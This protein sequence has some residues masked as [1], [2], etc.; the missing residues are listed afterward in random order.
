MHDR[1]GQQ[2]SSQWLCQA[3]Q[4]A[5][6]MGVL[7]CTPDS[8]SD[9]GKF[10]DVDRAV[11]HGLAMWN[12]GA[13]IIDVGGESTRPGAKP[14]AE[15]E[16]LQRVMPVIKALVAKGCKVS[17]DTRH[18]MVMKQA[19]QAGA[20]MI[21]DVS[22]LLFDDKSLDVAV[23]ATLDAEVDVCLM[24]MQGTPE[25]MQQAPKYHDVLSEVEAFFEKCLERCLCAGI[26]ES[27]LLLDPG[28]GFGKSVEDN[29]VLIANIGV[30][31]ERFGLPILL[32]VSR[33]S[34]IGSLTGGLVD[35]RELETAVAG[36]IGIFQGVDGVRVHDVACQYRA[37]QVASALLDV[38]GKY[39]KNGV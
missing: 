20:C 38:K 3:G 30:L 28:I 15:R 10:I 29:L 33:K 27:A 6:V 21:N 8:F 1:K 37:C 19:V 23:Q 14:I 7:N 11:Q 16:E 31:K 9:G 18:A 22:A 26:P 35:E 24:H 2:K 32:G 4:S 5:W 13:K 34:F 39:R 25:T 17:I 36:S 12:A